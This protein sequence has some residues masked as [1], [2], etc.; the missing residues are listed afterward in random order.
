MS[1]HRAGSGFPGRYHLGGIWQHYD[2]D[3]PAIFQLSAERVMVGTDIVHALLLTGVTS[4]LHMF[5]RNVDFRL[6]EALVM[7]SVPGGLLGS[8]LSTRVPV[9]WL[10]THSLRRIAG[11]GR[12]HAHMA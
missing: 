4:L 5:A 11:D 6:V 9:P 12:A 3:A 8:Y 2:D 10:Q 7:G 1:A